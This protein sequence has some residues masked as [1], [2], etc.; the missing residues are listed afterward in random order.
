MT[1]IDWKVVPICEKQLR[2]VNASDVLNNGLYRKCDIYKGGGGYD[3]FADI[4][5]RRKKSNLDLRVQFVVQLYGCTLDCPY[6]YVTRDGV[7]GNYCSIKTK[8]LVKDFIDSD[9]NVF[10]LMGGAPAIYIENWVDILRHIDTDYVFHSDLLLVE[11]EYDKDTLKEL[12]Q[13]KNSLYAVSVKGSTKEEFRNNTRT[14]FNQELFW[15]NLENLVRYN[16]DF[17]ITYTGMS[18]QSVSRFEQELREKFPS[19]C[20]NILKDSFN[21][22]LVKY[23]ALD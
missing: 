2:D 19:D 13:Y 16:I 20:D 10:H 6:C 1:G 14:E 12:A 4:Y 21:I 5:N 11:K 18:E 22:Q 23:A 8:Q 9:L 3:K 17:Y 15:K 7:L